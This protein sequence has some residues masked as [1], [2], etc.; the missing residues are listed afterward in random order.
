MDVL[1]TPHLSSLYGSLAQ[2]ITDVDEVP[3]LT[4]AVDSP[5]LDGCQTYRT[6]P[7][8]PPPPA[9]TNGRHA[10]VT[11]PSPPV[12]L[13]DVDLLFK[14]Q[15]GKRVEQQ[16]ADLDAAT[17]SASSDDEDEERDGEEGEGSHDGGP[18][19]NEWPIAT[20]T[21]L[22]SRGNAPRCKRAPPE[23]FLCSWGNKFHDGIEAPHI[24][25]MIEII[26]KNLGV[27]KKEAISQMVHLYF[28]EFV[29]RP[30]L[31]MKMLHAHVVLE[32]IKGLHT[33]S[34][35]IFLCESV[36]FW[37]QLRFLYSTQIFQSDGRFINEKAAKATE[38][39]Q[40]QLN[41]LYRMDLRK[42]NFSQGET[43]EDLNRMGAAFTQM[44]LF[45]QKKEKRQLQERRTEQ[46]ALSGNTFDF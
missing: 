11:A 19:R 41:G 13:I 26:D 7:T 15:Y 20:T 33:L 35:R 10:A 42:M 38:R 30:D 4:G 8:P 18:R 1:P 6:M 32:H 25:A 22:L 5:A 17:S 45:S 43:Q 2:R 37:K 23:C 16:Q 12:D 31:G 39:A 44:A 3:I 14:Q 27:I 28:K 46:L 40:N 9:H 34:A 24:N 29:Y 21:T 36:D